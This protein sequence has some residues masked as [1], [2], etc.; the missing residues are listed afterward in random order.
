MERWM[1]L[2]NL[3]MLR[4]GLMERSRM[5]RYAM[6]VPKVA[7]PVMTE[8]RRRLPTTTRH[9]MPASSVRG[10]TITSFLIPDMRCS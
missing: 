5:V 1:T 9:R 7:S 2:F 3:P 10:L 8:I 6:I 4:K